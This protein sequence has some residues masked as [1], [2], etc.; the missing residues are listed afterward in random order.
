MLPLLNPDPKAFVDVQQTEFSYDVLGRWS[1][2]TWNEVNNNGG[3][4]FDI[5]VIGAGMFGGYIADK[6]YRHAENIGLRVLVLDAGSFFLPTHTQNLPRLALSGPTEQV[7]ASNAQDPGP[8]NLVWGHPW[9]SNQEFPGLAYC[10]GGRSLYW[11]GWSPRLTDADLGP[12]SPNEVAWPK[13]A[14]DYLRANYRSV[15][16]EMG[17]W[18]TADYISGPLL[19]KLKTRFGSV[20]AA[21]QSVED[22]PLAVMGQAPES[23]LFPFDKYST[24]YMLLDAIREDIGRRWRNNIDAWRRLMLLT[25]AQ[26]VRLKTSGKPSHRTRTAGQWPAAISTSAADFARL[27]R[28]LGSRHDR[29]HSTCARFSSGSRNGDDAHGVQF[30]GSSSKRHHGPHPPLRD[31]WFAGTANGT[32]NGSSTCPWHDQRWPRISS[33]SDGKRGQQFGCYAFHGGPGHRT[34]GRDQGKPEPGM[35]CDHLTRDRTDDRPTER[36]ARR[37]EKELDQSRLAERP[38]YWNSASMG[39]FSSPR[40]AT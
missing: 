11:G 25:H 33:P 24:A 30:N 17:A 12:R 3:D 7:V 21:G 2:S 40:T 34:V 15:E 23:G 19:D 20:V 29:V 6:L 39:E 32:G 16:T 5:V 14:A 4:P 36:A 22:A 1:C 26:V 18:P 38:T 28:H 37:F 35:D 27:H 13:D 31:R 10:V 9:H 8:Q